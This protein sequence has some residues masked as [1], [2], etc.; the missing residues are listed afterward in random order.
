MVRVPASNQGI[1][2]P[3]ADPRFIM[4]L[5]KRRR[6]FFA[7]GSFKQGKFDKIM[8]KPAPANRYAIFFTP[9]SGSTRV[10]GL[11][12]DA[13]L[14]NRPREFFNPNF[15]DQIAKR[16]S[17]RNL[18]EYVEL[19][20]RQQQKNGHFGL[21]ITYKQIV[22]AFTTG[23][24]FLSFY[25]PHKTAWLIREDILSQAVSVSRLIQTQ[26]AHSPH[27]SSD[28]LAQADDQFHYDARQIRAAMSRIVWMERRTE[29]LI[30][31]AK[32]DSFR[33]SY[34]M[35]NALGPD[36]ATR[37]LAEKLGMPVPPEGVE[38]QHKKLPGKKGNDFVARFRSEH[39]DLLRS[40]DRKRAPLLA[41]IKKQ[42]E[43][44]L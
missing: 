44:F 24:R 19:I 25:Q 4:S 28:A 7:H 21:E 42:K 5:I 18:R 38:E 30:A 11:I 29:A 33:F 2:M 1:D 32:L 43:L 40:V 37:L 27:V 22:Y 12:A 8:S 41:L 10:S 13:E 34:E 15:L 39:P 14:S 36:R 23:A 9:R 17:A 26:V 31:R 6:D 3:L 20:Q 16:H 35:T